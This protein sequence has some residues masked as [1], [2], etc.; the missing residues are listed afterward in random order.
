[1]SYH[2]DFKE[3]LKEKPHS[4]IGK[5]GLTDNAVEHLMKLLKRYKTIKVKVLKSALSDSTLDEIAEEAVKKTNSHL[6]DT[7]GK[8]FILSSKH[9]NK[10]K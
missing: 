3:V 7:R 5:N 6:L 9:K 1:M 8:I 2:Q 10:W 4:N